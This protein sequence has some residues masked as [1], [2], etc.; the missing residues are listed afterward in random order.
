[1]NSLTFLHQVTIGKDPEVRCPHVE[2]PKFPE[3]MVKTLSV[4]H[5]VFRARSPQETQDLV[6]Y[7]SSICDVYTTCFVITSTIGARV[8]EAR[9]CP[10]PD[11]LSSLRSYS[12]LTF[13][14]QVPMIGREPEVH[15][16]HEVAVPKSPEDMAKSLSFLHQ[17]S[18]GRD[19]ACKIQ[20]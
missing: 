16:P 2:V 14:H 5:Q 1:M 10:D 3:D 6:F 7:P 8:V 9:L 15:C 20:D 11:P 13:L 12:R 19:P 17:V 18:I 4:L